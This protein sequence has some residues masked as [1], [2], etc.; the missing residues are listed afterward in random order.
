MVPGGCVLDRRRAA[1]PR[2]RL[3]RERRG[4]GRSRWAPS[5]RRWPGP[6]WTFRDVR[7]LADSRR[8]AR[9][10]ELTGLPN[11][12]SVFETLAEGRRPAGRRR[13]ERRRPG[14]GPRPVQGDQRLP[15]ARRRRRPAPSG[16]A[17]ADGVSP[18]RR[19]CWPGSAGTSSPSSPATRA[20]GARRRAGCG[21]SSSGRSAV[22]G[23]G[24]HHRGQ[25]RRRARPGALGD[26]RG[27]LQLADLAMYSAKATAAGV[28]VY[29][30]AARRG[31]RHR[32]RRSSSCARH[33]HGRARPALPAEDRAGTGQ[34]EGVEALVRW[35]HPNRGLLFPDSFID[36]AESAGLMSRLTSAVVE[37]A[38]AQTRRGPTT[39][40]RRLSR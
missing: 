29:D 23:M 11:R 16:G 31:G 24:L 36:L 27:L 40:P 17:T 33:R 32:S 38:L 13:G 37:M 35:Q 34:V 5:W 28:A 19:I 3:R 15:G 18:L 7:A 22:G 26:R 1:V 39:A 21:P 20:G 10:D 12:R 4:R 30:D 8:Q 6:V 9:T 25:R 14:A 2:L